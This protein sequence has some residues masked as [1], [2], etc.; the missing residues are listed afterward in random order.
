MNV[1]QLLASSL[2]HC[3]PFVKHCEHFPCEPLCSSSVISVV[4]DAPPACAGAGIIS[5]LRSHE[6]SVKSGAKLNVK[7]PLV[8]APASG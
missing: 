4:T 8:L 6:R 7:T 1:E 5:A 2:V 3:S